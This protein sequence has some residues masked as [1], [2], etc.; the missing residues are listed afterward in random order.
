MR[1][2]LH[3]GMGKTGTSAL[4]AELAAQRRRLARRGICYPVVDGRDA[5]GTLTC[6]VRTEARIP[7]AY[8]GVGRDDL[9]SLRAR[10]AAY[11]DALERRLDADDAH[12]AILS[13]EHF[14]YLQDEELAS[15]HAL[16]ESRFDWID[17]VAYV[18]APASYY[19]AMVQQVLRASATIPAPRTHRLPYQTCI[20]RYRSRF[21]G[22]VTVRSFER[23]SLVG[24]DIVEDF[25]S[26]AFPQTDV[27]GRRRVVDAVNPSMSAE[28]MCILQEFRHLR[29]PLDDQRFN[30]ATAE[31]RKALDDA[32]RV[33]A[34]TPAKLR[35]EVAAVVLA[36]HATDLRWMAD[37]LDLDLRSGAVATRD[38]D[39]SVGAVGECRRFLD[40][41]EARIT[42]TLHAV[43]DLVMVERNARGRVGRGM[44]AALERVRS[45]R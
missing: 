36:N 5:H 45:R 11:W 34:Q 27:L 33:V 37:E 23:D 22:A 44:A 28:A 6:L 19:V 40:V 2:V 9:A 24:A 41:D 38:S 21:P 42:E 18:R 29:Y 43:L 13:C 20:E 8:R 7:R 32:G 39:R 25:A 1:L 14:F 10:G 17:V 12:T 3:I 35:P 16:L 15:L 30:G 4:Q 26:V 31:L